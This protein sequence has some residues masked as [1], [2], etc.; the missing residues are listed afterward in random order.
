MS[1]IKEIR[2]LDNKAVVENIKTV[3]RELF[4]LKLKKGIT[5]LEKPHGLKSRRK[6]LA[7]LLTINNEQK[8]S[9]S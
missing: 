2:G 1:K 3:R 7:R 6:H 8:R 4:N 5:G 9:E